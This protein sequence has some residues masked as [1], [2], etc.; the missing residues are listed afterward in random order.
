MGLP[1]LRPTHDHNN[2]MNRVEARR[3]GRTHGG[4]SLT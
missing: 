4:D 1:L 3:I 2:H